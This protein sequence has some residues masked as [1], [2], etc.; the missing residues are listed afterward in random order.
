MLWQAGQIRICR[1]EFLIVQPPDRLPRHLGAEGM[2]AGI[3]PGAQGGDELL[4]SPPL[5]YSQVRP[6]RSQLTFFAASE[7]LP[8]TISAILVAQDVLAVFSRRAFGRRGDDA[9]DRGL[10]F[11]QKAS[12]E[13]NG[14][15]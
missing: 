9:R 15:Q 10:S 3:N 14:C 12:A 13:H 2:A 1:R 4:L 7:I 11:W 8:V 6:H 5:N